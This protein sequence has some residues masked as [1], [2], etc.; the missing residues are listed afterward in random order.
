MVIN[1]EKRTSGRWG[2]FIIQS[3][4][5][6]VIYEL[7]VKGEVGSPADETHLVHSEGEL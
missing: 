7:S 6:I 2:V 3:I 1:K 5:I 4:F